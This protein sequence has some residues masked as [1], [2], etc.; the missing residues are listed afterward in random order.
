[1]ASILHVFKR[2]LFVIFVLCFFAV[3]AC[4]ENKNKV[5]QYPKN[6][7]QECID[8]L[9]KWGRYIEKA[10]ASQRFDK[11]AIAAFETNRRAVIYILDKEY[12]DEE[13]R[14]D[15]CKMD[16]SSMS[17]FDPL[18]NMDNMTQDA[19]EKAISLDFKK[20]LARDSR[21]IYNIK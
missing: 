9:D 16:A 20:E 21:R 17:F 10:K 7:S 6:F 18:D 19:L 11:E 1:M 5:I 4:K 8:Y 15:Y 2:F 14:R 3:S 12:K 13:E